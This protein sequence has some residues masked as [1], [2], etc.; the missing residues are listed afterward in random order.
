MQPV[1]VQ[2]AGNNM[3]TKSGK[4]TFL[5]KHNLATPNMNATKQRL[6]LAITD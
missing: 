4:S 6:A 3:K 5:E 1:R 2:P